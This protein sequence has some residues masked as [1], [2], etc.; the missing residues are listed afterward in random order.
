M[1]TA[2]IALAAALLAA[3]A[4]AQGIDPAVA[5][6]I[7]RI[8]KATPLIDGHNDLPEQL[9]ENY[10]LDVAG[11]ASGGAAR[12]NP[13]MTDM[14]RLRQGRVGAQFWSVY[15]DGT[16]TGDEAIRDTIEQIDTVHRLV[17]AYPND[18]AFASTADDIVRI[19]KSG[20]V[21]SLIG[22]EGG[23]QIGGSLA[24]LRLFYDAGARY[25]TLTHN[26]TTE[27]ADS[28][29]DQPKWNGLSP[30]GRE[31]VAEMNRLGML[32]DLSHVSPDVMRQAIG[33]SKAPVIFSH[34]SAAGVV[35]HPRNVPDDVL[36]LLPANGGVV[37]VNWV[38]GFISQPVWTWTAD[39][40]GE[41]AR[42]K[43]I[44]RSSQAAVDA[45]LK[46]WDAAHPRPA[47]GVREV[48][49]HIEHVVR[50]A[51]YDHVGIGADLDG[52]PYTPT[53][54]EGVETYPLLFA[55]L[56]RRGWSDANLAKLAGG[57]ILRALRGAEATARSMKDIPPSM[58][59]LEVKPAAQ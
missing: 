39:R 37:M 23:R 10:K 3:P 45:G 16:I 1:R 7:D 14:A 55:E 42:L 8:L 28:A 12:A 48:A 21:A 33:L 46:A 24:A 47:T 25:M 4:G 59:T 41:E 2:S 22:I 56:I 34:S 26:Q 53:G 36:R 43:A 20:K 32:V 30:F 52:I 29:T 40:A 18:L 35:G 50:V 11:L 49:D 6:R 19:H 13:L 31:V 44:H 27:W 15:I 17:R 58:A 54:L 5:K 51:G 38:P 9:R 57:N